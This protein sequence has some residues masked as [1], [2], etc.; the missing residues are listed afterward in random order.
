MSTSNVT[1]KGQVTIPVEMRKALGL[2]AGSKV[3]FKRQGRKVSLE[4]VE[5]PAIE[6][7]FG[8]LKVP[9][10]RGIADIDAALDDLRQQRSLRAPAKQRG[11]R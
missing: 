2:R 7:L 5:E 4:P 10:T 1:Q 6:S 8:T 11:H 9:R 3:R